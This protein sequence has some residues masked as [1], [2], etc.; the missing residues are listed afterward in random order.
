M[1]DGEGALV[2]KEANAGMVCGAGDS[3]GLANAVLT[4]AKMTKEER[5]VLGIN[6]R[7]YAK[8]EFDRVEL[9]NRLESLLYEA[10]ASFSRKC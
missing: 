4:L 6:G 9:M 8:R 1:L 3:V 7:Q 5:L 10:I 2:I